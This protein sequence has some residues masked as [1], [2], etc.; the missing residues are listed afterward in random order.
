VTPTEKRAVAKKLVSARVKPVRACFLVG[1]PKS[2]WH[3]QPKP[4]QD[5]EL[6]QR[7]R[8]LALLHPRRGYRFIHACQRRNDLTRSAGMS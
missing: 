5:N 1:L 3:Y 8:E 6:R 7:I 4:H 2:T